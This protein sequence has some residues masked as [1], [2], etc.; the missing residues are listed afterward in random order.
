MTSRCPKCGRNNYGDVNKCSFCGS[1]L[2]F[3][4]GEVVPEVSEEDIQEKMSKMKGERLRNPMMMGIGG[5][6]GTIGIVLLFVIYI[7]N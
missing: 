3:I 2:T 5:I 6:V 4:P 7:F 1:A